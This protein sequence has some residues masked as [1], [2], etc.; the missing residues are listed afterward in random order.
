M[1]RA[2]DLFAIEERITEAQRRRARAEALLATGRAEDKQ[3]GLAML[4]E[5]RD[6]MKALKSELEAAHPALARLAVRRM[7]QA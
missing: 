3:Q 4:A 2:V 6:D 7:P 1:K 5:V